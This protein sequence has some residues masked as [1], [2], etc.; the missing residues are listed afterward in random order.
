M[1]A[2]ARF[3]KRHNESKTV[4]FH[5]EKDVDILLAVKNDKSISFSKLIK[6]LLRQHYNLSSPEPIAKAT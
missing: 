6:N 5:I 4:Q 2:N 1:R 3:R